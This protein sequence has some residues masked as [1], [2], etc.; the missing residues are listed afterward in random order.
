MFGTAGNKQD[1]DLISSNIKN[2]VEI[3]GVEGT[4]EDLWNMKWVTFFDPINWTFW[5]WNYTIT[6]T[7][8]CVWDNA[9][10]ICYIWINASWILSDAWTASRVRKDWT[11]EISW[12]MDIINYWT[13]PDLHPDLDSFYQEWDIIHINFHKTSPYT[14]YHKDY[15]ISTNS[16]SW[17]NSWRNTTWTEIFDSKTISWIIY[18]VKWM[19]WYWTGDQ[20][21]ILY[22]ELS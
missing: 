13:N 17:D 19:R 11:E 21:W 14:T 3:F 1:A 20:C 8:W 10:Y 6:C 7:P 9:D 12:V 5:V 16:F 4:L 22:C 18:T 15:N 2:W